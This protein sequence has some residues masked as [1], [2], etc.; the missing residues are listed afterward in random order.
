MVGEFEYG[1]TG[2]PYLQVVK[3]SRDLLLKF[4]GPLHIS[5][6]GKNNIKFG[7]H[8]DHKK[9]KIRSKGVGKGSHNIIF[10]IFEPLHIWGTVEAKNFKFCMQIDHEGHEQTYA[11]GLCGDAQAATQESSNLS[12]LLFTKEGE[13]QGHLTDGRKCGDN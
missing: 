7:I 6:K 12:S 2:D 8:I 5:G 9:C 11:I 1:V 10:G 4:S 13:G 3:L